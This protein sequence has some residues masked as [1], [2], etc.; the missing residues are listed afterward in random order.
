[1]RSIFCILLIF[2]FTHCAVAQN[3]PKSESKAVRLA[4][5]NTIVP[6]GVGSYIGFNKGAF[7][8]DD[9]ASV[10]AILIYYGMVLGPSLGHI[11][12]NNNQR[13]LSGALLRSATIGA[14]YLAA[15]S[16]LPDYRT[17]D[18]NDYDKAVGILIIGHGLC[19]LL[20]GLDILAVRKSFRESNK[21]KAVNLIPYYDPIGKRAALM[22]FAKL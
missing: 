5:I 14:T 6:I 16:A 15:F 10:G 8:G 7:L 1:M 12:S 11:Y 20:D 2:T 17:S 18:Y 3:Q 9:F 21:D 4:L 22:L 19:L 13:A